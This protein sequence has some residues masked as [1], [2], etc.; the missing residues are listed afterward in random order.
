LHE[1]IVKIL[2]VSETRARLADQ[3]F[4]PVGNSPEEFGAYIKSELAKWGKV[5]GDAGIRPE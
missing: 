3:G 1:N 4:E 5:I 2:A